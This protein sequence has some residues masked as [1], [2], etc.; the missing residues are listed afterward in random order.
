MLS[1]R[2]SLETLVGLSEASQTRASWSPEARPLFRSHS[3]CPPS[4]LSPTLSVPLLLRLLG[5]YSRPQRQTSLDVNNNKACKCR[6]LQLTSAERVAPTCWL[7]GAKLN[8]SPTR[9][10][11]SGALFADTKLAELTLGPHSSQAT[12]VCAPGPRQELGVRAKE[13]A[14]H[15]HTQSV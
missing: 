2:A 5:V 1:R 15:T 4:A 6:P 7:A 13:R 12:L 8:Q 11:A 10:C 9:T 14:P 3:S